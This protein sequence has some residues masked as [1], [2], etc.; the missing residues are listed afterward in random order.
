MSELVFEKAL[1]GSRAYSQIQSDLKSGL[2]HAYIIS[3]NDDV[4]VD[5]FFTLIAAAIFCEN[6][7]SACLNCAE[8]RKVLHGNH[9]DVFHVN[10]K[11]DKIK[12]EDVNNMLSSVYIK[13]LS[14]RKLYFIHRADLM[15][16]QA[17]NKLLKTFEEPPADV[18]VFL[19][20]ANESAMLDTIKSR[21]RTIHIDVFDKDSVY[22]AMLALGCDEEMSAVASACS[23][24]MLGKA[25]K[26]AT[27]PEYGI[28]Y[29]SALDLMSGLNKSSDVA[30]L[31]GAVAN[32]EN[33][34]AF[35][36]VLSIIVRDMMLAESQPNMVLSKHVADK[37][38][39]LAQKYSPLALAKILA[40]INDTRR[41]L[42]LNVSA[43]SAI[44]NLLFSILEVRHKFQNKT[45]SNTEVR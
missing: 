45:P 29:R 12:V 36:D 21:A 32:E 8:C 38:S 18:T 30:R 11:R 34:T 10:L 16:V 37:I 41:Q 6:S 7:H 1:K 9:A 24:G 14:G 4:V 19:G 26:I 23:E 42:S 43:L 5:E 22:A 33:I 20:V 3:S 28:L 35:L 25:R 39:A 44:D 40:I 2:S 17:Q 15:N 27:S 13:S 31:D